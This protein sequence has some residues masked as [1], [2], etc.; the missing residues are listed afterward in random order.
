MRQARVADIDEPLVCEP[1]RLDDE[2]EVASVQRSFDQAGAQFV[3]MR[4]GTRGD[5][6][7]P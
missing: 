1:C 4:R 5:G 3:G 7:M 2:Q 6:S